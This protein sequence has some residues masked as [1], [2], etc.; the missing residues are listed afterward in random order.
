MLST[1]FLSF[2]LLPLLLVGETITVALPLDHPL[3]P[4]YLSQINAKDSDLSADYIQK[5][6]QVLRFDLGHNGM[7]DIAAYNGKLEKL[8]NPG[9]W[10]TP[11]S[12]QEWREKGVLYVVTPKIEGRTASFTL[13]STTNQGIKALDGIALTGNINTDRQTLHK[14]ADTIHSTLF[15]KEGIASRRFIF[16]RKSNNDRGGSQSYL[17][18]A[19]WDG[20]NQ[21]VLLD[22]NHLIVT[23]CLIPAK[24]GSQPKS[25]LYVS[26]ELGQ[27]KIFI[28]SLEGKGR[29]R[30]TYL[31]GNQLT[32]A[33]SPQRDR[34]AFI[35]DSLGNPDLFLL[36]IM[37]DGTA[38]EP[39]R[40]IYTFPKSTNA[41][42]SFGPDGK[43]L[44]FVSSKDG[45]T[46]IYLLKIPEKDA[47]IRNLKPQL[48]TTH[49]KEAS[50]PSWSPDGS[51]I[52]FCAKGADSAR[53][54]WVYD[55]DKKEERQ[56][57]FG[58][59]DKENPTWAPNNLHLIFN[60]RKSE[61]NNELYLMNLNQS[62][63]TAIVSGKGQNRFPSW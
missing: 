52:A 26:Y 12:I 22:S 29:N 45:A 36:E 30:V 63:A 21:E 33:I 14:V 50:A 17:V 7:T 59:G 40:R 10:N 18:E 61:D 15:N 58:P 55:M 24:A 48:I 60:V 44:A 54:I 39:P 9:T 2:L 23:P 5:L 25:C 41:S 53:Q 27:P 4:L 6:D 28:S 37:E 43:N 38:K 8:S 57:T 20:A 35:N 51:K 1:K 3:L 47:N 19:D 46:R 11:G 16:T 49:Q 42:P 62:E 13:L 34:I 31:K 32:P 56:L